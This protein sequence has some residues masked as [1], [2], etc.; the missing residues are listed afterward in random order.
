[1]SRVIVTGANGFIGRNLIKLLLSKDVE[2]ISIDINHDN[3]MFISDERV[4]KLSSNMNDLDSLYEEIGE[5]GFDCF[6]HFAWQGTTGVARSDYS[7]QMNNVK[8]TCD[9]A[10]LS[11]KLNCKKFV[12]TGTI[13]EKIAENS[14]RCKYN[15]ENL[16]YGLSKLYA[17]QLLEIVSQKNEINYVWAKLS[18]IYG[19]DN[20][21]GNLISYTLSQFKEN[22]IP[23]YGPCEQ[24]Y[25]FMYIDD[26]VNLLFLIGFKNT[27]NNE[28]F[29]GSGNPRKLKEYLEIVS[30]IFNKEIA[31]GKKED[32]GVKYDIEWFNIGDLA[33][34]DYENIKSFEQAITDIKN[35]VDK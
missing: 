3:S 29:L 28:Y 5:G 19:G 33:E 35:E 6:Y 7:M 10:L 27:N 31:I 17:H 8:L 1:M 15:S 18:N 22:K 23:E 4:I 14:L 20:K 25:D 32:D 11:K 12:T 26:V 2:V 21:N 24:P 9:A 16:V 30:N 13:T 34:F